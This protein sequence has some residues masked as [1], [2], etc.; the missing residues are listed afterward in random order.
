MI[1]ITSGEVALSQPLLFDTTI[2]VYGEAARGRYTDA[3]ETAL[4][5]RFAKVSLTDV[6]PTGQDRTELLN[7]RQLRWPLTYW[8]PD[9]DAVQ[10]EDELGARWHP[11]AGSYGRTELYAYADILRIR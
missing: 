7:R 4:P 8:M 2:T 9:A 1:P 10:V 3:L 6:T 5:A 11:I